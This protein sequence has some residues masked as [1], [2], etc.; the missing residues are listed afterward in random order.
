MRALVERDPLALR[1]LAADSS[2]PAN[3][4]P[5]QVRPEVKARLWETMGPALKGVELREVRAASTGPFGPFLLSRF[6]LPWVSLVIEP[7]EEIEMPI[8]VRPGP[9]A[10]R[11]PHSSTVEAAF[12]AAVD[13]SGRWLVRQIG[14]G[15]AA[16]A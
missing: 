6:G 7:V 1:G 10:R 15:G 8:A 14:T 4:G 5:A 9:D 3:E 2:G 11:S 16:D 13:G 12:V